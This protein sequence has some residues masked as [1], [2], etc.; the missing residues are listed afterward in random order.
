MPTYLSHPELMHDLCA[1]LEPATWVVGRCHGH[2]LE[3]HLPDAYS[4]E[5]AR[6]ELDIY[7]AAWQ[8]AHP[9]V[10]AYRIDRERAA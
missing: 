5:Q 4:P 7:L 10:E 6:R 8:V 9:G 2:D 3:V 1:H